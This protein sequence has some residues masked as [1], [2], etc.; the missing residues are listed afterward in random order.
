M[1]AAKGLA[2]QLYLIL[3]AAAITHI[4]ACYVLQLFGA[5]F[6]ANANCLLTA[7]STYGALDGPLYVNE[8]EFTYKCSQ[9]GTSPSESQALVKGLAALSYALGFL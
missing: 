6:A 3:I 4:Q 7:L 9:T 8:T 2:G 5:G 1:L